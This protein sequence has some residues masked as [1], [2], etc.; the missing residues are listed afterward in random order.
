[1]PE[2]AYPPACS[3]GHV[4]CAEQRRFVR[5]L[6]SG[7]KGRVAAEELLVGPFEAGGKLE[8][9]QHQFSGVTVPFPQGIVPLLVFAVVGYDLRQRYAKHLGHKL[10]WRGKA[11]QEDIKFIFLASSELGDVELLLIYISHVS[12]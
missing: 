7:A 6:R 4:W 10:C 3:G 2:K 11:R 8:E 1:M 5:G 9:G 12:I